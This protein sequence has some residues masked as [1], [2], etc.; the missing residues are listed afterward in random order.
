MATPKSSAKKLP[1]LALENPHKAPEKWE[2]QYRL[3]EKM[4]RG[5]V[6]PVDD[7]WVFVGDRRRSSM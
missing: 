3:I 6:A 2:E 5:I 1:Q 4:R 7:M